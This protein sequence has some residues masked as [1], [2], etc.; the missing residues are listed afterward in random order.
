MLALPGWV[1][2]ASAEKSLEFVIDN[3]TFLKN[4]EYNDITEIVKGETL[5]G[6]ITKPYFTYH[7]K[8]GVKAE[9]GLILNIPF[10]DENRVDEIDPMIS[11]HYDVLPGWRITAGTLHRDHPL[12]DALFNDDLE[13]I[14]PAEQGFQIR[15]KT[16]HLRQDFWID[17]ER[18]ETSNRREKFSLGNYTQY[19]WDGFMIDGQILWNHKGGQKNNGGEVSNNLGLAF[20]GGVT[21]TPPAGTRSMLKR[22]G[23][24]LHYIYT[25]DKPR[26]LKVAV[27][28]D[29]TSGGVLTELFAVIGDTDVFLK[30]WKGSRDR[31]S[32][33]GQ[34]LV[35][36]PFLD[37]L[38]A[39]KGDPL[40]RADDFVQVGFSRSWQI[41]DEVEILA[42]IEATQVSGQLVHVDTVSVRWHEVFPLWKKKSQPKTR[43]RTP[44]MESS[45]FIEEEPV[46][47]TVAP[48]EREEPR[49]PRLKKKRPPS[50]EPRQSYRQKRLSR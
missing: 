14:D 41:T 42:S 3:N 29:S 38:R 23:L 25:S 24:N 40:Y 16:K 8:K 36:T 26:S 20:G 1:P 18:R 43:S 48:E 13:F 45:S 21:F 6:N 19:R 47:T 46:E 12:L 15:A 5:A 28:P 11:L 9:L 39:D 27:E 22:F 30:V 10:G 2:L 50:R 33:N 4:L 37:G 34:T 35:S 32:D 17:W 49:E 31:G 7:F 44:D